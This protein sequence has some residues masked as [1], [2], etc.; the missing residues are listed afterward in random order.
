M[1]VSLYVCGCV[2][3]CIPCCLSLDDA[4]FVWVEAFGNGKFRFSHFHF[5]IW[6]SVWLI[7]KNICVAIDVI[8]A[9][10]C[11]ILVVQLIHFFECLKL[12]RKVIGERVSGAQLTQPTERARQTFRWKTIFRIKNDDVITI[13][14]V[15][16]LAWKWDGSGWV[17]WSIYCSFS[18][19]FVK[20]FFPRSDKLFV[21]LPF[22]HHTR[23]HRVELQYPPQCLL[24]RNRAF[25]NRISVSFGVFRWA[26]T[27]IGIRLKV[28]SY[29]HNST[30]TISKQVI[31]YFSAFA[32]KPLCDISCFYR[33]HRTAPA[34]TDPPLV[35]PISS[36]NIL[37]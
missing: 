16:I 15:W 34:P 24:F 11:C 17:Q 37:K 5:G 12:S 10:W 4:L 19:K 3:V 23:H 21:P 20:M 33:L 18:C 14:P 27:I 35:P 9:R 31:R 6:T 1:G 22:R 13:W 8:C 28:Q 30:L 36:Y 29:L 26:K 2:Y 32:N 25:S 7:S